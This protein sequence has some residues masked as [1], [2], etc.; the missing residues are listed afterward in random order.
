MNHLLRSSVARRSAHSGH[1][2]VEMTVVVA[3]MS[4]V[5]MIIARGSA[6]FYGMVS[7]LHDRAETAQELLLAREFIRAD[8]SGA[9]TAMPSN[10][11]SLKVIREDDVLLKYGLKSG[12]PDLGIEYTFKDGKLYREDHNFKET[13]V[14]AN[15]ITGFTTTRVNNSET[16]IQIQDGI[17]ND[18]HHITLVWPK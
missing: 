14:V 9:D 15:N 17:K 3:M 13:M 8:L 11:G 1:T 12:D 2:L 6:P 7:Q 10:S 18:V 16:R 4:I 5:A